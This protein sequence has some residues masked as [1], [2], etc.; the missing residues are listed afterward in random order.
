MKS[1]IKPTYRM[2]FRRRQ[3]GK[4][5][6][7]KRLKL[8]ESRK[9]RLVVRKS[10]KYIYVSVVEFDEKGDKTIAAVS[11]TE[12]KK[13]GWTSATDN[14]PAAYLTG[15]IVAK[16]A[17]K[18]GVK[19]A[20]LDAGLYRTTKG[21]KIFAAAKGAIDGGLKVNVSEEILPSEERIKGTH[22]QGKNVASE[23]EK[24]KN[25]L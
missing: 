8:L 1:K 14:L 18:A 7:D 9:P 16:K 17:T 4:T 13:H 15:M 19:E 21:N 6:Y 24:I 5:D 25:K 23:F 22:I 10:L 2:L 3:E 20:I 12:L 11:S